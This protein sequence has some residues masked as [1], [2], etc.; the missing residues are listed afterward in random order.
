M[1]PQGQTLDQ[2]FAPKPTSAPAPMGVSSN[3]NQPARSL[4]DIFAAP[5]AGKDDNKPSLSSIFSAPPEKPIDTSIY[6]NDPRLFADTPEG[7]AAR[8]STALGP[9]IVENTKEDFAQRQKEKDQTNQDYADGKISLPHAFLQHVGNILGGAFS[10]PKDVIEPEVRAVVGG[11][12][13][14][15]KVTDTVGGF[16]D[17]ITSPL[18][19]ALADPTISTYKN[20][21]DTFSRAADVLHQAALEKDPVKKQRL[22]DLGTSLKKTAEA[23]KSTAEEIDNSQASAARDVNA[24]VNIGGLAMGAAAPEETIGNIAKTGENVAAKTAGVA[25]KAAATGGKVI[26]K[27]TEAAG[28]VNQKINPFVEK[29]ITSEQARSNIGDVISP[30]LNAKETQAA[31]NEGRVTRGK[32]SFLFGKKPDI[33]AQSDEIN[34]AIDTIQ[35]TIPDAGKMND[36]QLSSALDSK[37]SELAQGLQKDMANVPIKPETTGKVL[38]AWKA[39]KTAQQAEPEFDGFAGSAKSQA[40]FESYLKQLEWDVTDETGK[41]KSPTPKTLDDIWSVRKSYDD[42]IAPNVKT[43]TTASAPSLQWQ[44]QMWLDN[45]SILNAVINDS[46]EGLGDVSKKAF[47]DMTDMYTARQNIASKAKI[48]VEGKSGLLPSNKKE[49]LKW[50]IGV[51]GG[52]IGLDILIHKLGL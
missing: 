34:H 5:V 22:T 29:P 12:A 39:I 23:I 4:D 33:V 48:D 6:S 20:A 10:I 50:G 37:T 3:G 51:G 27:A 2:I 30:K 40:R 32:D 18:S 42:S 49:L 11:D 38:S 13:N 19:N 28:A 21:G 14:E 1:P 36:V 25:E 47:S 17:K 7:A 9:K 26:D 45:R 35:N 44:K 24:T 31:I 43:A 8:K 16:M 52:A 41:F 15:K 46:K